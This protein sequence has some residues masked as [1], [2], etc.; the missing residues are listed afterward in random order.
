MKRPKVAF[1]AAQRRSE[2]GNEDPAR[3][4]NARFAYKDKRHAQRRLDPILLP[5]PKARLC[6]SG[7][8]DPDLGVV[9]MSTDAPTA[10]R[11]SVLLALQLG[12]ARGLA[13]LGGRRS[14]R[15]PERHPGTPASVLPWWKS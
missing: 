2:K 14:G 7:Q 11:H 13:C 6:V 3:I 5:K 1:M 12:L 10:N 8:N 9:D 4:L 15:L